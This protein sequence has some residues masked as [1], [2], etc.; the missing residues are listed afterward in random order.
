[1]KI[2]FIYRQTSDGNSAK[3]EEEIS[4][5]R[6]KVK[7]LTQN[8]ELKTERV[9]QLQSQISDYALLMAHLEEEIGSERVET[10]RQQ[11]NDSGANGRKQENRNKSVQGNAVS[12][13]KQQSG[14]CS[15]L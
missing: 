9:A 3:Y 4:D 10:L 5:L 14:V 11:K 12:P 13:E 7:K 1:M 2:N 8:D 6:Q 15:I